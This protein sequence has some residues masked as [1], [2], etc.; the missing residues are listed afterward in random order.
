M[1]FAV[2]S[3]VHG[4]LPALN[5]VLED[6]EKNNADGFIFAGDYCLSNPFPDEC[7]QKIRS[8]ENKLIIRG[9]E[10]QYLENL[11][12]KDRT[13]W[14]D[15]QMQISY[16][17]YKAVSPDNLSYILSLPRTLE[18]SVNGVHLHMSHSS[19]EFIAELEYSK[20]S[21]FA[22]AE[23]YARKEITAESLRSELR[24]YYDTSEMLRQRLSELE[25]GVYVFGH[26]HVQWSHVSEDGK[27]VLINPGSCGLPL[28][29]IA[30]T[31]PYTILDISDNGDISVE[32]K[33]LPFDTEAYI[34]LLK[35]S[36]QFKEARVWSNVIV[37]ELRTAREHM[38]FFIRYVNEY[39]EK[40]N[41][42]RRP[43]AVDTWENAYQLW[44]ED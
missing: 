27:T 29:G 19:A 24:H 1:R 4:N 26:S 42:S 22:V 9:N 5:A 20:W 11:I 6:A 44:A 10:E 13:G 41:D 37:R 7:I 36:G 16:Y 39:A 15:G 14:T 3:D 32:E 43:F 35:Q 8:L 31:V 23:K 21:S 34:T 28:D 40:I 33:R 12:G 30:G 25:N 38:Y 17:C 18:T 2:V